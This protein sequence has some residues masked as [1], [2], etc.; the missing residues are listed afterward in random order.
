VL[1]LIVVIKPLSRGY[2]ALEVKS[3]DKVLDVKIRISRSNGIN[4]DLHHL[5]SC[6]AVLKDDLPLSQ[7]K[8]GPSALI[9]VIE[10]KRV[11]GFDATQFW[12]PVFCSGCPWRQVDV[13]LA[14]ICAQ[15]REEKFAIIKHRHG[16]WTP[17]FNTGYID[18]DTPPLRHRQ[19]N[20]M[21]CTDLARMKCAGCPLVVCVNCSVHLDG[22]CKFSFPSDTWKRA[23]NTLE[24]KGSLNVLLYSCAQEHIRNDVGFN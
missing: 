21:I 4:W 13:K 9:Q 7:Y 5:F 18:D 23:S 12:K 8:I 6:G 2:L 14:K 16:S 3:S 24:G 17:F 11:S 10:L 19:G 20:C 15:C 1:T 22:R